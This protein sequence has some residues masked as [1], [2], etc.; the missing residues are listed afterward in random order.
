MKTFKLLLLIS[1]A[2]V[3]SACPLTTR[4]EMEQNEQKEFRNQLSSMQKSKADTELKYADLQNDIRVI[5]GRTDALDHN[6]QM[7]NQ[8]NRQ[9]IEELKKAVETQNEK[10]KLLQ[11]HLEAT[12]TRLTAAI[13]ALSGGAVAPS[14]EEPVVEKKSKGKEKE[15]SPLEEAEG[16]F[17]SKDFKKAIVKFQNYIDKNPK[18]KAVAEA[19]YKIGVCFAELGLKKDA[20]EFLKDVVDN[21]PSSAW[22]KKAKF[23]LSN[24]K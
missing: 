20:K 3:L 22:A 5:A 13:N 2:V 17:S 9:E 14:K 1:I 15:V 23:R 16:H 19:T 18:G 4:D 6:I 10:V 11:S 21:Y 12:E 24:L 8:K 7:V